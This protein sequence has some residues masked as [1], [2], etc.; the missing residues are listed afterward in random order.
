MLD[1]LKRAVSAFLKSLLIVAAGNGPASSEPPPSPGQTDVVQ[2]LAAGPGPKWGTLSGLTA[3]PT[4]PTRLFAITDHDSAPLR[5]IEIA[6]S[7]GAAPTV[8]RQ[9]PLV[10]PNLDVLDTEAIVAKPEGGFWLAA[11]GSK[12]DDPPNLLI[13][14]DETGRIGRSI[15]LP[16]EI[17]ERMRK[18]GVEGLA[19]ADTP[20]GRHLFV[21]F[22][23]PIKK[24][25]DDLA[26]IGEVNL[27]TGEWRF[28]AYPLEVLPDERVTGLSEIVHVR[29]RKF[30]LIERDGEQGEGAIKR[31]MT[32]DLG[33]TPGAFADDEPPV[34]S[35]RLAIDL[36]P[37]FTKS[38]REVEKEVE[39]LAIAA[40][41]QV[42]A[43]TDNDNERP[44]VL[45]RLG[46][47]S[48]LFE[49]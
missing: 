28:Y 42:Y 33:T 46:R 34:L 1:G 9:I 25:G 10:G 20:S 7:P 36:V 31:V 44:T 32:V 35:K 39:G 5:I 22:Q 37:L 43:I 2:E 45:L 14:V 47:A 13:E 27:A 40:D 21:A 16:D 24:D 49:H 48:E 4:D 3:H 11:E 18:K 6:V 30:A 23:A 12:H 19:L 15:G 8:V 29:D 17:G 38:G 26:R 41:G